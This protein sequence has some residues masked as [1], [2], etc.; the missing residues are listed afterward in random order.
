MTYQEFLDSLP[1]ELHKKLSKF[2]GA[3]K[4]LFKLDDE[5]LCNIIVNYNFLSVNS[6]KPI[7]VHTI[8]GIRNL[9]FYNQ[10]KLLEIGVYNKKRYFVDNTEVDT[11]KYYSI[12][13]VDEENIIEILNLVVKELR[14]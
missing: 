3:T 14:K 12:V 13:G 8:Y 7:K 10:I 2:N 9:Q 5:E 6:L 1:K 11:L 4:I